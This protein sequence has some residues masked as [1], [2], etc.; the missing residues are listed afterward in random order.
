MYSGNSRRPVAIRSSRTNLNQSHSM[1]GPNDQSRS[2]YQGSQAGFNDM[3]NYINNDPYNKDRSLD[4]FGEPEYGNYNQQNIL[5]GSNQNPY[6]SQAHRQQPPSQINPIDGTNPTSL[7][8]AQPQQLQ[9]SQ[10][11]FQAPQQP[12][13]QAQPPPISSSVAF[14]HSKAPLDQTTLSAYP[15]LA[16]MLP[17]Q[18]IALPVTSM[19]GLSQ[20]AQTIEQTLGPFDYLSVTTI[21]SSVPESGPMKYKD[22]S[23]YQGQYYGGKRQGQG[24][25][26]WKDGSVYEGYWANDMC[27][28]KGR[29]IHSDGEYYIGNWV[30]DRADGSGEL[31]TAQG[32]YYKG[33]FRGDKKDGRGL[34]KVTDGTVYEGEFYKGKRHGQGMITFP[35][36]QIYVGDFNSGEMHGQG[37]YSWPDG[38]VYYGGFQQNK[39]HGQG[40]FVWP[41]G[42]Q[43]YSGEYVNDKKH[44]FGVMEWSDGSKYEGGFSK[45][46]QQGDGVYYDAKGAGVRGKWESGKLVQMSGETIES[47]I[48]KKEDEERS[49]RSK[50]KKKSKGKF[51]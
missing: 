10:T 44:G 2:Y 40:E 5:P 48:E 27:H 41:D 21:Q 36:K 14:Q 17:D 18:S 45:G 3:G 6:S 43:R 37:R 7:Q 8:Q 28:G 32:N 26:V 31:K 1:F 12:Q 25:Q 20:A 46:K 35:N 23:T 24:R 15:D 13:A 11:P 4:L 16:S 38:R 39:M 33:D 29:V 51:F 42:K 34:E 49:T 47:K 22:G 9:Q 19:N 30:E 50:S